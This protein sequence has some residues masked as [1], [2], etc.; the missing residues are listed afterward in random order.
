MELHSIKLHSIKLHYISKMFFLKLE[1][2]FD[3]S[4]VSSTK[5]EYGSDVYF[6][7]NISKIFSINI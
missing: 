7:I 6:F 5:N 1:G 3:G 2:L 4:L